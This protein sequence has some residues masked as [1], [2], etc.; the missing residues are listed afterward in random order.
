MALLH[1]QQCTIHP[2]KNT[3]KTC[4]AE[5]GAHQTDF[6]KEQGGFFPFSLCTQVGS[7][8]SEKALDVNATAKYAAKEEIMEP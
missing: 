4:L 1:K 8:W 6:H 5:G 7:R 3:T 2:E